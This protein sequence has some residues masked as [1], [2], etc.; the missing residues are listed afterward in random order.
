MR[1]ETANLQQKLPTAHT[2][3]FKCPAFCMMADTCGRDCPYWEPESHSD[4]GWCGYHGG[5]TSYDKWCC[6]HYYEM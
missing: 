5:Y 4:M 3:V 2:P 1:Y 6:P